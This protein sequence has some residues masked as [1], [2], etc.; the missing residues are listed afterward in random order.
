MQHIEAVRCSKLS[1]IRLKRTI[2]ITLVPDE[3]DQGYLVM[4]FFVET[5]EFKDF[6]VGFALDV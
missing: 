6:N 2:D 1:G 3:E 5:K 4:K